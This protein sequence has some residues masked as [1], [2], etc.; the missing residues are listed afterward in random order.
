MILLKKWDKKGRKNGQNCKHSAECPY[1]CGKMPKKKRNFSKKLLTVNF[2][3]GILAL[4]LPQRLRTCYGTT[5]A[6]S[7]L[8]I[9]FV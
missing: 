6:P 5:T 2:P 9:Y 3:Y 7:Q 4:S 8:H 1:I